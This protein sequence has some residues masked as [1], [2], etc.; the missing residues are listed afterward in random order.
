[1]PQCGCSGGS[2]GGGGETN[3][4]VT[5]I[6]PDRKTTFVSEVEFRGLSITDKYEYDLHGNISKRVTGG[7]ECG[8]HSEIVMMWDVHSEDRGHTDF[9]KEH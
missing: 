4:P 8:V 7:K 6:R 2:T 5:V 1:M 3:P 9:S